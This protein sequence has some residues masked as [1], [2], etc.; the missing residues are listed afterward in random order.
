MLIR[1]LMSFIQLENWKMARTMIILLACYHVQQQCIHLRFHLLFFRFRCL[2][3]FIYNNDYK[4]VNHDCNQIIVDSLR[5]GGGIR[6]TETTFVED[7]E[8]VDWHYSAYP[9]L[10][11]ASS[12][13]NAHL[14]TPIE[15][16]R[17]NWERCQKKERKPSANPMECYIKTDWIRIRFIQRYIKA[18]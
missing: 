16:E 9:T 6:I 7:F 15:N 2:V 18:L 5:F 11:G 8:F 12:M 13:F 3:Q 10:L 14:N 17:N 4:N 1:T